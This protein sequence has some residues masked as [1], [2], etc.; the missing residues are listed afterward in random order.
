[1]KTLLQNWVIRGG[2]IFSVSEVVDDEL[3][4]DVD[5]YGGK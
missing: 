1:M 5:E 4:G 2:P 3:D